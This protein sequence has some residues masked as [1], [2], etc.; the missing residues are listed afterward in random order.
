MTGLDLMRKFPETYALRMMKWARSDLLATYG[1]FFMDY[2]FEINSQTPVNTYYFFLSPAIA[3]ICVKYP[4][5]FLAYFN[6]EFEIIF[7]LAFAG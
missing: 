1:D 6:L 5:F 2:T 3:I 7:A 4:C